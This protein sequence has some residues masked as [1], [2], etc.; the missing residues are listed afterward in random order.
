MDQVQT[1]QRPTPSVA[2][3]PRAAVPNQMV[4]KKSGWTKWLIL[5]LVI[6]IV[7]GVGIGIY[8]WLSRGG[9]IP[10]PPALPD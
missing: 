1:V 4:E 2:N 3:Q 8:F 5:V 10:M 7:I 9:G 6:L